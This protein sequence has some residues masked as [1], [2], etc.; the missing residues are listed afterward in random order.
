MTDPHF[1]RPVI[2]ATFTAIGGIITAFFL[3]SQVELASAQ[4][5]SSGPAKITENN[6][7]SIP[8]GF[9]EWVFLGAPLTPNGLNGGEAGFPEF[10]HVYIEPGAYADYKRTGEFPEGTTIV[11]ELV[12]LKE[13]DYD[14]GSRDE[15]SGRG[16]FAE[17]FAGIDMMV[18]NSERFAETN[19]WGFFNFGHHAPPYAETAAATPN[20]ACA[21]CHTANATHDMVFTSFYPILEKP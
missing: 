18:K 20:D 2:S 11:K 3:A 12:L 17:S 13:G 5:A 4:M 6:E 9:R 8:A 15:A 14:D 16:Y 19:G 7:T 10:H 21:F 1:S